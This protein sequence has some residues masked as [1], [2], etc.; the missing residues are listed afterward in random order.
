MESLD[1]TKIKIITNLKEKE[2]ERT[3]EEEEDIQDS[4]FSMQIRKLKKG[5]A[6]G[7]NGIENEAWIYAIAGTAEAYKKLVR[8]M[9]WNRGGIIEDWKIGIISPIYKKR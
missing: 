7:E 5:K 4:E 8:L 9:V 2:R 6:V 1:G 3:E